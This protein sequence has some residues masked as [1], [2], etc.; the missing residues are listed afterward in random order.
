MTQN[1]TFICKPDDD[2]IIGEATRITSWLREK[3]IK[4]PML[5][6]NEAAAIEDG[7]AIVLG[8]DGTILGAGRKL[9]GRDVAILGINLGRVGF[10]TSSGKNGWKSVLQ[11]LLD[12]RLQTRRCA[13]LNWELLRAG[14]IEQK[15]IAV[16]DVVVSRGDTARLVPLKI[17]VN[18]NEF[19]VLRCDGVIVSS[20]I[21]S[22]GY[23][24]SAGGSV[25]HSTLAAYCLTPICPFLSGFKPLVLPSTA[26]TLVKSISTAINLYIT[27]DGQELIAMAK[28]DA[29]KITG[30][31][32]ALNFLGSD[33]HFFY[34]LNRNFN[35][36]QERT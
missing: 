8:G 2:K 21:G 9:A 7:I 13:V 24:A 17:A 36:S 6:V 29:I 11:A 3:G 12:N 32:K 28:D 18:G 1:V 27:I 4:A 20:P 25:L 22:S 14:K 35:C 26:H 34:N 31:D 16:N 15:G 10:L 30:W 5:P 23:N 19:P 33:E